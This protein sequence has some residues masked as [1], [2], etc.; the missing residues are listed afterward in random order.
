[1]FKSRKFIITLR[2]VTTLLL[3]SAIYFGFVYTTKAENPFTTAVFW[4]IFW[5][6]FM[7]LTLPTLGAVFC[8]ICP[9]AFLGRYLTQWGLKKTMPKWLKNP[10][11]SLAILLGFYWFTIYTFPGFLKTPWISAVFFFVLTIL[12]FSF[13]F[14]FKD[15]AYCK[16]ICPIGPLTKAYSKSS[17][18]WLSTYQDSCSDCKTFEC[19]QV[20]T[21]K[22]SPFLFDKNNSMGDCTLCMDCAQACEAVRFEVKKPSSSLWSRI[23]KPKMI[24][25]WVYILI[26]ASATIAMRFHHALGRSG[27]APE[28][29][30]SILGNHIKTI[31]GITT[32]DWVGFVAFF[33]ALALTLLLTLGGYYL[34]SKI[35]KIP[36][37]TIM[38]TF[39]YALAPLMLM[40]AF[41]HIW[42]FFFYHYASDIATAYF[43]LIGDNSVVAPLASRKDAWLRIFAIFPY[44]A[45][46]WSFLI[47][48]KRMK[49]LE[50]NVKTKVLTF[51]FSGAVIW[52]YLFLIFF[53][54]YA[55]A[56]YGAMRHH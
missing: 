48:Y 12:A 32:V 47:L 42:S 23:K 45:A 6:F 39:G 34:T 1:I 16:Y 19:A 38:L 30:W 56:T 11:I 52:F 4:A 7:V 5:P 54:I 46:V 41:E 43:W 40:G 55:F 35:S 18:T 26:L 44:M 51:F 24:D 25:I 49:L 50:M 14:I 17:F 29:P 36:F 13:F 21:H 15:M 8:G 31:T 37:K 9:H 53:T 10:Y 33:M 3:F 20:C 2:V 27:L 28:M 22:Q